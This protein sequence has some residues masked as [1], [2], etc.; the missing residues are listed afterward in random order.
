MIQL[1]LWTINSI[2]HVLRAHVCQ[3]SCLRRLHRQWQR[4]VV[5]WMPGLET[6]A[7][8]EDGGNVDLSGYEESVDFGD[9]EYIKVQDPEICAAFRSHTSCLD[10]YLT[11]F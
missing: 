2:M 5:R 10:S 1:T 11:L 7:V 3:L 6:R 8:T 9:V 4:P